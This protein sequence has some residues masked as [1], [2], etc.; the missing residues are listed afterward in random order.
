VVS[1]GSDTSSRSSHSAS[2][3]K[4]TWFGNL[5]KFKPATFH[6]LSVYDIASSRDACKHLLVAMG[7]SV[8]L[9]N[10]GDLG[11]RF[12]GVTGKSLPE[13]F[14]PNLMLLRSIGSHG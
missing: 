1:D 12:D 10:S 13:G 7:V 6:L 4:P 3:E 2:T 14:Q 8:S 9:E 5:F 11:C